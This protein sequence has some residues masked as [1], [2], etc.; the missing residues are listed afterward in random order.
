MLLLNQ[1]EAIGDEDVVDEACHVY[2]TVFLLSQFPPDFR[3]PFSQLAVRPDPFEQWQEVGPLFV[4]R[5]C[6][7][8]IALDNHLGHLGFGITGIT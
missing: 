3:S 2:K 6:R 4:Q 8:C 5:F 1:P 7:G